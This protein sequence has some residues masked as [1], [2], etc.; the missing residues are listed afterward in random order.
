[1]VCVAPN[2]SIIFISKAYGGSISDKELTNRS[3]YLVPVCS[4]TIFDKGFKLS[5]EYTERFIYYASPLGR[6]NAA[7]ITPSQVRKIKHIATLRILREQV[8]RRLKTFR[9]LAME[10]PINMLKL[11]DDIACI[12]GTLRNLRKPIYL[13]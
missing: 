10:Y 1:M 11:F 13:E 7:Q 12:C 2:S 3:E 4:R 8:T 6:R 9:I 5:D